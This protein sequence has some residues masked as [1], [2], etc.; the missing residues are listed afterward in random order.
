MS[1]APDIEIPALE[2]TLRPVD[3]DGTLLARANTNLEQ[4]LLDELDLDC[5]GREHDVA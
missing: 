3:P 4:T 2:L 1:S 5:E